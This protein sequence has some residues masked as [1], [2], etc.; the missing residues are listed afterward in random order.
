MESVYGVEL[1][2]YNQR[3]F[4]R[5]GRDVVHKHG[6]HGVL[7]LSVLCLRARHVLLHCGVQS[8]QRRAL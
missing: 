8:L 4:E 1:L 3:H 7:V 2:L 6:K 5:N